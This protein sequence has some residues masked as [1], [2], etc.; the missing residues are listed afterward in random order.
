VGGGGGDIYIFNDIRDCVSVGGKY[1]L[2]VLGFV[3]GLN[4]GA[5]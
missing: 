1:N 4:C 2:G 5:D 3:W